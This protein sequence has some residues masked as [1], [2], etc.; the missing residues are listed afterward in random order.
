MRRD[1]FFVDKRFETL[2][3]ELLRDMGKILKLGEII[4]MGSEM[5]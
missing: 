2:N 1:F 4:I 5:A 3:R